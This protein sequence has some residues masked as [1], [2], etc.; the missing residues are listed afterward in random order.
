[1][2]LTKYLYQKEDNEMDKNIVKTGEKPGSG[3]YSCTNCHTKVSLGTD[4][5][6]P[7]C[8]SCSNDSFTPCNR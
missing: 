1:M 6:M 3:C 7:P 5:K 8:P 4:D 2:H